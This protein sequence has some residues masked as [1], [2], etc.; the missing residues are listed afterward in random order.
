MRY[1][2]SYPSKECK[3]EYI[4]RYKKRGNTAEFIKRVN[5]TFEDLIDDLETLDCEKIIL[6][7]NEFLESK[8]RMIID[9]RE[10]QIL[11]EERGIR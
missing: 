4:E 5:E 9:L 7:R 3:E 6:N 2:I 10:N 1:I 8:L 11:K